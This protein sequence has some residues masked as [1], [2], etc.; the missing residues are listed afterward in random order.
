MLTLR[1]IVVIVHIS[2]AALVLGVPL[3]LGRM[4]RRA[5]ESKHDQAIRLAAYEAERRGKLAQ[6]AGLLTL[7]SGILLIL[8]SG[9]FGEVS[10]N[11]HVAM[12]LMIIAV[13]IGFSLMG[14]TGA[15]I[16]RA[17]EASP[18]RVEDIKPLLAKLGMG[19][20][21]LQLL[22]LLILVLMLYRF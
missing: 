6:T 2:L 5:L 15:A 19:S 7:L 12:G 3:G 17:V 11:F 10:T 20:G 1:L 8:M 22:W 16:V 14:P 18:P 21:V 9:G 4:L 13:G